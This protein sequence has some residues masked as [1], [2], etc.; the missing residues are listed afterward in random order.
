M[1]RKKLVRATST[2]LCVFTQISESEAVSEYLMLKLFM[3][4]MHWTGWKGKF[5]L[6]S[7]F[8]SL[9]F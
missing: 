8:I 6:A 4:G 7:R 1:N 9:K 3:I 2:C 5:F